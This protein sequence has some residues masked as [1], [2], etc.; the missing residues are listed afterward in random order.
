MLFIFWRG[1]YFGVVVRE[2]I[3]DL[4]FFLILKHSYSKM[5]NLLIK[6]DTWSQGK[7]GQAIS[8]NFPTISASFPWFFSPSSLSQREEVS[9]VSQSEWK[10]P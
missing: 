9:S 2:K 4:D 5:C 1:I 6:N 8:C 10:V 7:S 3:E